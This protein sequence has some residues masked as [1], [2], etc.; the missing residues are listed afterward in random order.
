MAAYVADAGVASEVFVLDPGASQLPPSMYDITSLDEIFK[1]A[2]AQYQITGT[3]IF[4]KSD[5]QRFF[6]PDCLVAEMIEDRQQ[7]SYSI[8]P[9]IIQQAYIEGDNL[10]IESEPFN[11]EILMHPKLKALV[12]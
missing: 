12:R 7:A 3:Y 8:L 6:D 9:F 1:A 5:Y 4:R 10:V 11:S 2:G